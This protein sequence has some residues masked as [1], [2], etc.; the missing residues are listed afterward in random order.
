MRRVLIDADT[1][2]W[3]VLNDPKLSRTALAVLADPAT[4]GLV[5]PAT[6]WEI[7]IKVSKRKLNLFA[8]YEDF[9]DRAIRGNGFAVLPVEVRHA[10][11]LATL[12]HHDGD[13]FDRMIIAQSLAESIEVVGADTVF[14]AYGVRRI[15]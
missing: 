6:F 9:M 13:P 8:P 11:R 7:A 4:D 14:D 3:F 2:I 12:P 15:W 5:S 1:L 10:A